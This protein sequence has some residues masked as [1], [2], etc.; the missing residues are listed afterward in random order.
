MN[1]DDRLQVFANG[2]KLFTDESAD[3]VKALAMLDA[4]PDKLAFGSEGYIIFADPDNASTYVQFSSEEGQPLWW[5]VS[6][7]PGDTDLSPVQQRTLR[8]YGFTVPGASEENPHQE[9]P[10]A[11]VAELPGWIERVFRDVYGLPED[12]AVALNGGV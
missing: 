10:R 5:E 8:R 9:W 2:L 1:A 7:Q 4:L 3:A 12:Y 6:S 11:R